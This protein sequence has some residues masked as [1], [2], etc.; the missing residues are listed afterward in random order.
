MSR[1]SGSVGAGGLK[2][3]T[4]TKQFGHDFVNTSGADLV[5]NKAAL[6]TQ[7]GAGSTDLASF[8][9]A[10]LST[11]TPTTYVTF[12]VGAN[13]MSLMAGDSEVREGADY[14]DNTLAPVDDATITVPTGCSVR[15]RWVEIV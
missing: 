9:V 14:D 13:T 3:A 12:A 8:E 2:T 11:A 5:L 7:S 10:V 6:K 15:V 1:A 4:A